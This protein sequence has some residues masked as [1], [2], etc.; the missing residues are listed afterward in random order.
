MPLGHVTIT[1]Q[2]QDPI[3]LVFPLHC[4]VIPLESGLLT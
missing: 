4:S 2:H 3:P 1:W